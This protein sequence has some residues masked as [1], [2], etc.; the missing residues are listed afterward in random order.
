MEAPCRRGLRVCAVLPPG[1]FAVRQSGRGAALRQ[2]GRCDARPEGQT[3]PALYA[4]LRAVH[5]LQLGSVH[6]LRGIQPGA[7][8]ELG[9]LYQSDTGHTC[10]FHRVPREA[11]RLAMGGGGACRG[12][13]SGADGDGGR[14]P[15]ARGTHRPVLCHLR[16]DKEKGRRGGRRVHVHRGPAGLA[17]SPG[18][19]RGHGAE[20]RT[21]EHGRHRRLAA[22]AAAAGGR[23]VLSAAVP[24]LGGDT[25]YLNVTFRYTH[26][27]K[28]DLAAALRRRAL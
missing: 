3:A 15:A 27:H 2:V 21:G 28:P 12:G 20:R 4:G 17:Y 8:R 23:R 5:Q 25:D 11:E 14:V 9:I 16:G 6:L 19:H 13:R 10:R 7:G 1:V 22:P 26:V 24:L 18:H